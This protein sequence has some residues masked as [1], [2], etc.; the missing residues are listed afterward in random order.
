MDNFDN[1]EI[2]I[3]NDVLNIINEWD[4]DIDHKLNDNKLNDNKLNDNKLNDNKLNDNKLN[5][6]KLNDNKYEINFNLIRENNNIIDNKWNIIDNKYQDNNII[7]NKYQDNKYQDNKWNI[8]DNKYQDNNIIDNKYQD[9]KYQDNKYQENYF[10]DNLINIPEN[11]IIHNNLLDANNIIQ[12]WS[13]NNSEQQ[14]N[15]SE[16]QDNNLELFNDEKKYPEENSNIILENKQSFYIPLFPNY[17]PITNNI[18]DNN[19]IS[20]NEEYLEEKKEEYLEEKKEYKYHIIENKINLNN[21]KYLDEDIKKK[22]KDTM[23]M[24]NEYV[25][26]GNGSCLSSA[27]KNEN[28]YLYNNSIYCTFNC[29]PDYCPNYIVCNRICPQFIF[30]KSFNVCN[31]CVK[32]IKRLGIQT[33]NIDILPEQ[34]CNICYDND[35]HIKLPQCR[36]SICINCFRK[37]WYKSVFFD[38]ENEPL[39][40]Q[41]HLYNRYCTDIEYANQ[42][43]KDNMNIEIYQRE[44]NEWDYNRRN[45]FHDAPYLEKCPMCRL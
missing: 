30:E 11:K 17:N 24:I 7:D 13:S 45:S 22:F 3:S 40:P 12:L 23:D 20:N 44:W 8:I 1:V 2:N 39:F 33:Y 9:N 19:I 26:K 6:N 37:L 4:M 38:I 34:E 42:L 36:H 35:I 29:I 16:Q 43:R 32:I 14:G 25:C 15:N 31:Y 10:Y 41:P 21:K 27:W 28:I 18:N 5:D